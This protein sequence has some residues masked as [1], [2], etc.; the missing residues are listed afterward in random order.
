[1]SIDFTNPKPLYLQIANTIKTKIDQ[2]Q[3]KIGDQLASQKELANEYNVSLITVK[4]AIADLIKEGILFSRV[5]KGIFVAKKAIPIRLSKKPSIGIVLRDINNPFFSLIAQSFENRAYREGYNILL[6]NSSNQMDKEEHQIQHFLELGVNGLMIASM[7]HIYHKT[8]TI[9]KL[10][11]EKFPY[12]MVSYSEDKSVYY[13]GTDH[14]KGGYIAAQHLAKLGYKK[15]GYINAE[16]GNPIGEL[17]KRGFLQ[18]LREKNIEV[19][20]NFEYRLQYRGDW[21]DYFAGYEIG[22]EFAKLTEKPE[23]MFVYK[24]LVALGFQ[25]ALLNH[26]INV[27]GDVAIVGFDDIKRGVVAPVPLTTI[28]QP[29]DQ[30][31]KLAFEIIEK[32]IKNEFIKNP[33]I[34]LEPSLVIRESCGA[35]K[36]SKESFFELKISN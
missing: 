26:G 18:A 28:H 9:E 13:V 12:V 11:S 17:R 36:S 1:M 29:T 4:K 15:I 8:A 32:Q 34:I 25:R 21:D 23:A 2:G 14:E 35:K 30:I 24:D 31:G 16:P 27:P 10:H 33:H 20:E 3:L 6:S 19:N 22:E 5:G 7:S